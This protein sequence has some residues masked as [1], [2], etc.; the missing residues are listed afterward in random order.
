VSNEFGEYF[1]VED[2][3]KGIMVIV[4]KSEGRGGE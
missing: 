2:I 1:L 4:P 3:T